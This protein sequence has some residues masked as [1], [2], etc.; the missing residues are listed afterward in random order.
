M[1]NADNP[2][3]QKIS[4]LAERLYRRDKRL[5]VIRAGTPAWEAWRAFRARHGIHNRFMDSQKTWTVPSEYPPAD[6]D[7]ELRSAGGGRLTDR[8]AL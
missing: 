7:F 4:L 8:M 2:M 5:A 3:Q 1:R 6:I